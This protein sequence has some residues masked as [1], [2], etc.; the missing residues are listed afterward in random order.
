MDRF[1]NSLDQKAKKKAKYAVVPKTN[2][3]EKILSLMKNA[4]FI[5]FY[6]ESDMLF[7]Y[8][9]VS[10]KYVGHAKISALRNIRRVS[11]SSKPFYLKAEQL[12]YKEARLNFSI[13]RT[14]LGLMSGLQAWAENL[15][16]ELILE[17]NVC[18]ST[19][20]ILQHER[21]KSS[22]LSSLEYNYKISMS[23]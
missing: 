7:G 13:L 8:Y 4:G 19:P 5:Q 22:L 18:E 15:G 12:T 20:R 14:D 9:V 2:E 3:H 10:L 6:W 21:E 17:I 16:G 11:K 23:F 1:V